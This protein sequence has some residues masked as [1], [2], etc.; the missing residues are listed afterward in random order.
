MDKAFRNKQ[1]TSSKAAAE[2]SSSKESSGT[3]S[4][5]P[6][7][8]S[9]GNAPAQRVSKGGSDADKPARIHIHADIETEK[10]NLDALKN[11]QVGHAWVSL[12]WKKPHDV[13]TKIWNEHPDHAKWLSSR[14]GKGKFADP[15]GFWP[16]MFSEFQEES[17]STGEEGEGEW[18][19][20]D[21]RVSYKKNPFKSYVKGQMVHPD[22]LHESSVRATQSF[23]VTEK[24]AIA[25]MNYAE[26]KRNARYSVYWYN[27]TTFAAG[28]IKA[29]GKTPPGNSTAG[30][31]IPNT[32][33]NSIAANQKKKIGDTVVK[34]K[35]G[36]IAEEQGR[37]IKKNR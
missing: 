19:G 36:N 31:A 14:A 30:I 4:L 15:F 12:E 2:P 9:F 17:L 6:P 25:A 32:L 11:A 5:A 13:P 3:A 33:Y 18:Q 10:M 29:A 22:N 24:Q 1:N 21:D 35:D 20:A 27:C 7:A 28:A 8:L 34:D 23:D 26:S 37:N 16:Y